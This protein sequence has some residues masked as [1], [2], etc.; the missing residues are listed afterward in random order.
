L[1]TNEV[2]YWLNV[3]GYLIFIWQSSLLSVFPQLKYDMSSLR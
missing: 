1:K 3:V 2:N